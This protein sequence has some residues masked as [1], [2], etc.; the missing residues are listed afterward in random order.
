MAARRQGIS[1]EDRL[2][3]CMLQN[4]LTGQENSGPAR[5][6]DHA[7]IRFNIP[8]I[9]LTKSLRSRLLSAFPILACVTVMAMMRPGFVQAEES[10]TYLETA[11]RYVDLRDVIEAKL[12]RGAK[13][14]ASL[15]SYLCISYGKLKQYEK[16]FTCA[17]QLEQKTRA[18]EFQFEL[19]QS[20]MFISTSDARPLP[21][22]LR[23]RAHFEL[24]EYP[25]AIAAA[26]QALAI[27]ARTPE[28]G[29]TSLYPTIRYRIAALE[30]L[31]LSAVR[32][33]DAKQAE[34]HAKQI[35]E[36]SRPFIGGR[37]WG[38]IKN[39]ALSQV[40]MAL[41]RYEEAL[42]YIPDNSSGM[43]IVVS[44]VNG[45]GPYAYRGDSTTTVI[46]MPRIIMRGKAL[47]ETGKHAEAKA[48]FDEALAS[49]RVKDMGDLYWVALFER[50]RIAETE[51]Q[52][53]L[54][55]T[56]YR[57]AV[58]IVE[59][60]RSS[61]NTESSKIG[62]V[63]DKQSLY[64]RLIG[65][66]VA[67]GKLAEAFD[68]VERSKSRALVDMLSVKKSFSIEGADAEKTQRLLQK[69]DALDLSTPVSD[70]VADPSAVGVRNLVVAR[71]EL[72]TT[73]P[74]FSSLVTVSS[75]P[76]EEL[77][78]LLGEDEQLLEYYYQGSELYV[79]VFG[80]NGLQALKLAG[81]GLADEVG[82]LRD[83]LEERNSSRWQAS[84]KLLY[85]RL[86]KP[87]AG[88][89]TARNIIVVGH[90]ALHYLPF[91]ALQDT[92]GNFLIDRHSLRHLPSAGVL[93]YLRRPWQGKAL[94]LLI[95]GNPDL[96]DPNLDLQFAEDE[97]KSIAGLYPGS[98][99]LVRKEASEVGFRKVAA[100]FSR[101]HFA[102]H[103]K[104][105]PED[106]LGSG[107]YLTKSAD[108]DGILTA[109]EL[110]SMSLD[111]DLVT[112]S[113]CETGLGKIASGDDVVGLTRG[114][115]YAGSRSIVA[116]L[117]S[118][119]DHATAT[120]MQAF[121]GNLGAMNKREALRQ[122]QIK[123]R[124]SFPHPFFWAAFQI[125]GR[126]E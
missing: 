36:V 116:S 113:A 6:P 110:Y 84:A 103:G 105:H 104:F 121:Y 52:F 40:Y 4:Q 91:A 25:K 100:G 54:A 108:N 118:V 33:G 16:L 120:L 124:Q 89:L 90:G 92:D 18:G 59:L 17:D 19:D 74:E 29:G 51:K 12:G 102:T 5:R 93:K 126:A 87:V 78:S 37:M 79:F 60:Q 98:R 55:A 114:F 65:I 20:V 72:R 67:Q 77:K 53:D 56:H 34:Q 125:I 106:P 30:V 82:K 81:A 31:A 122:A 49:P 42:E 58:D 117:W 119:D 3:S 71:N 80:R 66:L 48:A 11:G 45:L 2:L 86:W 97:A 28:T 57:Q 23:A 83:E 107:L 96:G 39:N 69:I 112:L 27:I 15:L 73:A 21:Q 111:T 50:G 1:V 109:G 61:I 99:L 70:V 24:A 95:L 43:K 64:A 85:A 13:A 35:D 10:L 14:D 63:G 68:Y 88:L 76:L 44:F 8:P 123:A 7:E 22:V 115:L 46:E 26:N 47:A 101:L 62:F 32:L 9:A 38:W 41:G 94:Q 75:V